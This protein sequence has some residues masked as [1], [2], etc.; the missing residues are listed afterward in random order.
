VGQS[1]E[2]I[3]RKTKDTYIMFLFLY[4]VEFLVLNCSLNFYGELNSLS[5]VRPDS[6]ILE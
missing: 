2:F 3:K 1:A 4:D 6:L 5:A